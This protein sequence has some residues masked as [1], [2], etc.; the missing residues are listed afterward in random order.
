MTRKSR[1]LSRRQERRIPR[2]PWSGSFLN[3]LKCML[4][5]K[6]TS[7]GL[8]QDRSFSKPPELVRGAGNLRPPRLYRVFYENSATLSCFVTKHNH[9]RHRQEPDLRFQED[10]AFQAIEPFVPS[11]DLAP[12][13]I[14][15]HLK[16]TQKVD[17][18][19]YISAFNGY[20]EYTQV[21]TK[22][23]TKFT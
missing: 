18:S 14:E 9:V 17:P 3:R 19:S 2:S 10:N 12:P 6:T 1:F 7:I 8:N 16:W 23:S 4:S 15:R 11:R 20:G 13:R 21:T 22:V 5:L